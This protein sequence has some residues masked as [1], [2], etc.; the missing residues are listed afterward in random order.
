MVEGEGTRGLGCRTL[1]VKML[2]HMKVSDVSPA[3]RTTPPLCIV[4]VKLSQVANTAHMPCN[5][6]QTGLGLLRV[7]AQSTLL[8]DAPAI[9]TCPAA[10]VPTQRAPRYNTATVLIRINIYKP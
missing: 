3:L 2:P 10:P 1:N 7:H 9:L 6:A 4:Y 8:K 5:L